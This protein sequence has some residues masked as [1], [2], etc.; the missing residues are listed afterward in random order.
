MFT[1]LTYLSHP[2]LVGSW[3]FAYLWP[4]HAVS[5]NGHIPVAFEGS[6]LLLAFA[7]LSQC[8]NSKSFWY[9]SG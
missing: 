6:A 4:T 7:H 9:I 2:L 3:G 5:G 8:N 1:T